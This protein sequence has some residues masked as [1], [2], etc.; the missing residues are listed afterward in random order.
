MIVM[1][2][3]G[4]SIQDPLLCT[5][6]IHIIKNT[7]DPQRVVVFSA[8]EKTTRK[9]LTISESYAVQKRKEVETLIDHIRSFHY[10]LSAELIFPKEDKKLTYVLESYFE[11][12]RDLGEEIHKKK[13]LEP[14]LQDSILSYGELLSTAIMT[15][16]LQTRQVPAVLMDAR[17]CI[18]TDRAFTGAK[19]L[20]RE[21]YDKI[22]ALIPKILGKEEIPVIQGFIGS[23]LGGET[24][25]LGFEGSDLTASLV[26]AALGADEI[27]IWKNVSGI[28]TADPCICSKARTVDNLTFKEAYELSRAGAKVLH[29]STTAP[30]AEKGIPIR[31]KNST[32]P[33][34]RGTLISSRNMTAEFNI[35]SIAVKIVDNKA[36]ITLVGLGIARK[37]D[38]VEQII[39]HIKNISF[40]FQ[41]NDNPDILIF[42]FPKADMKKAVELLHDIVF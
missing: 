19:P 26:G 10:N 23:T 14:H 42:I 33:E 39:S 34:E 2:F 25:T 21:T 18:I 28:M 1:K 5:R 8:L 12:I 4:T 6:V 16:A 40:T 15:S 9:L 13:K 29:P 35:K 11:K 41:K 27:Q 31:I 30:A 20:I 38:M 36:L 24:T 7:S 32:Q 3:G 22:K 37:K 17:D